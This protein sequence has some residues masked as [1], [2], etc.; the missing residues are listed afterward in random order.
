MMFLGRSSAKAW[1]GKGGEGDSGDSGD[2]GWRGGV[3]RVLARSLTGPG[4]YARWSG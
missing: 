2:S 3:G 1:W 4:A